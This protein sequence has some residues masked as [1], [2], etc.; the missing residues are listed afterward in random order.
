MLRYYVLINNTQLSPLS[1][2]FHE[3]AGRGRGERLQAEAADGTLSQLAL[4]CLS[5]VV[6]SL[7]LP[8]T[9]LHPSL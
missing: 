7:D 4:G 2:E 8:H 6:C 3:A 9:I 1:N 5:A